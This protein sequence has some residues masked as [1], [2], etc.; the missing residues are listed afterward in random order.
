MLQKYEK[1]LIFTFYLKQ[2]SVLYILIDNVLPDK[3]YV[4]KPVLPYPYL[5]LY[6][7]NGI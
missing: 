5:V 4:L 2:I 6:H 1:K 7:N 3:G